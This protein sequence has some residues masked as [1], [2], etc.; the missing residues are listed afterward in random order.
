[1]ESSGSTAVAGAAAS[2]PGAGTG[3]GAGATG[4]TGAAS[5]DASLTETVAE[6]SIPE[7]SVGYTA[8]KSPSAT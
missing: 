7:Y 6:V 2:G 5:A 8:L 1:M 3:P 4:A